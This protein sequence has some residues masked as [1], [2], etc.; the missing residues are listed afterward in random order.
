MTVLG[1]SFDSVEDNRAFAESNQFPFRL[2]S[3]SDRT[4]GA[5][6]GTVKEPGEQ[7]PEYSRRLTFL[8]DPSLTVRKVY[9]VADRAGHAGEVLRDLDALAG[10]AGSTGP[11]R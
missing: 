2:L 9:E 6:Y 7:Y 1:A 3:D 4:T 5:A 11:G 10:D 8:I